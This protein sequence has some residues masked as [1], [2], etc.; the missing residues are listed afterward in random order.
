MP[1]VLRVDAD[2]PYGRANVGEKILSKVCENYWLPQMASLGYLG[3]LEKF[4]VFLREEDIYSHIYFRKCTLP[5]LG[6]KGEL[7]LEG[8]K[9]GLHAEDTRTVDTLREELKTLQRHFHLRQI[10]SFTKHGSGCWKSG[11]NHYPLYEP[12]KYLRWADDLGV[13]FLFG[14]GEVKT[15]EDVTGESG[16]YPN[17]YW[18][19]RLHQSSDMPGFTEAV[20][21]AK[22]GGH[23][24]VIIHPCNF[25]GD[26][27]VDK[28][29]RKLVAFS[30]EEGVSW[31]TK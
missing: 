30:K 5:T 29:M 4:L 16:F 6:W 27:E 10:S 18:I 20:Q 3:A 8:H 9:I 31:I 1:L 22:Q 21:W 11:R 24:I 28:N 26:S 13:P 2:K 17:M 12:D 25:V 23:V 15:A 14:N 19:D 7:L